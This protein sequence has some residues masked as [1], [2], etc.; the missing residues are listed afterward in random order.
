MTVTVR[1]NLQF[2]NLKMVFKRQKRIW[3]EKNKCIIHIYGGIVGVSINF[4]R[5][6][7]HS[8][9]FIK[10]LS[11]VSVQ[12]L[13]HAISSHFQLP[14]KKLYRQN[15]IKEI[16]KTKGWFTLTNKLGRWI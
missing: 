7:E 10:E 9:M 6:S 11:Y 14:L 5:T 3:S 4:H 12:L 16:T 15:L 8:E 2:R 1:E 13:S